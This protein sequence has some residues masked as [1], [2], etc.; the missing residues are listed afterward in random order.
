MTGSVV[1]RSAVTAA[2][3]GQGGHTVR[4]HE[5]EEMSS[6]VLCFMAVGGGGGRREVPWGKCIGVREVR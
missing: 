4:T 5:A 1:F 3:G 2:W 6:V